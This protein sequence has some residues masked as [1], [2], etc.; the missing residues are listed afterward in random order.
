MLE[1]LT[2]V[3]KMRRSGHEAGYWGNP[4]GSCPTQVPWLKAAFTEGWHKGHNQRRLEMADG[5]HPEQKPAP[6]P[7]PKRILKRRRSA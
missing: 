4:L 5:T 6:K 1:S 3:G 7:E 2:A